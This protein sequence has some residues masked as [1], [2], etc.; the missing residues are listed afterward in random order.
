MLCYVMFR[1]VLGTCVQLSREV[2]EA[3]AEHVEMRRMGSRNEH[4]SCP[5]PVPVY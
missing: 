2:Q 4:A 3:E 1:N 5:Q